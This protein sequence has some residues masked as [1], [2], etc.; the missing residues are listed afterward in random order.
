MLHVLQRNC[1]ISSLY[2]APL[3]DDSGHRLA[4]TLIPYF[5]KSAGMEKMKF[6]PTKSGT[7]TTVKYSLHSYQVARLI[8]TLGGL[9]FRQAAEHGI[10]MKKSK[11][12]SL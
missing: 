5:L 12:P 10:R 11:R 3:N 2:S 1:I 9:I 6:E 4:G 8:C 7:P